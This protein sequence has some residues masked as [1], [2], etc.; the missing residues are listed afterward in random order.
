MATQEFLLDSSIALA[1]G[2]QGEMEEAWWEWNLARGTP[3]DP[4]ALHAYKDAAAKWFSLACECWHSRFGRR[5]FG[6]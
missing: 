4:S 2:R 1:R 5:V 6:L 3:S